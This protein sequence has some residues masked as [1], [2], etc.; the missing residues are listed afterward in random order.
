MVVVGSGAAGLT[1]AL[2]ASAGGCSVA[3]LEKSERIGGASA[4][5]GG[6]VWVPRNAHMRDAGIEDTRDEALA[7]LRGLTD[8]REFDPGL[9]E[10]YVDEA[11]SAV[12][13]LEA[14]TPLELRF[15]HAFS[16]YYADRPGGKRAGR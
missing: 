12:G 13:F 8:G 7:Y 1:A 5:S 9:I 15:Y 16:D 4:I 6:G 3:V 10:V 11:A 14:S 2:A